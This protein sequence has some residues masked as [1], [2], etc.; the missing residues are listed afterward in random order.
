MKPSVTLCIVNFNGSHY[1]PPALEAAQPHAQ[2]DE[3]LVIDNA[4]R[5]G[6]VELLRNRFPHCRVLQLE[7]NRGPGG[8]R[9]AG[10]AAA[11]CDWILFQDNDV[12]LTPGCVSTLVQALQDSPDALLV[13]PRVLYADDRARVQYDSA[14]CHWLGLMMPRNA[15]RLAALTE[16]RAAATSSL[17]TACFL[18]DRTRCQTPLQFDERFGF[19]LEDHDFGV[20][21]CLEGHA[22]LIEPHAQVLHSSGTPGLSF[23]PGAV[24][25]A[26]RVYYLIRNRWYVL[27]KV[28][29]LRTLAVLAP[30]LLLYEFAQL[31]GAL[32]KGWGRSWGAALRDYFREWP[33]L[34]Q[35]RR[36][37]Q[38]SRRIGDARLL[39]G[40][41]LPM[42]AAVNS[43][44]LERL[45]LG[46]LQG[47]VSTYWLAA[48]PLLKSAGNR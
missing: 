48:R 43:A 15:N 35:E 20:R 31:L 29:A 26:A 3:I 14:D 37:V 47:I 7:S 39:K 33:R 34:L 28:F 23:R 44:L 21:A 2:F 25:P 18:I 17:V 40:G 9:N 41:P 4:S 27:T 38:S 22:L 13:A 11:Q 10:L 45:L 8:A 46:A 16:V 5:D 1:L 19:N 32:Y 30:V 42:T 24:V 6:S 12:R 36:D